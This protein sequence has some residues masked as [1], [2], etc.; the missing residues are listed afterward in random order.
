MAAIHGN[1]YCTSAGLAVK[2]VATNFV[3]VAA[4]STVGGALV[5]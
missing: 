2:T 5:R 1:G 4:V 3:R